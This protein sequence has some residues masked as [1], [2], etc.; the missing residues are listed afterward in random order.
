M[1][2]DE[3]GLQARMGDLAL[4]GG[5]PGAVGE[6]L[7]EAGVARPDPGAMSE[8]ADGVPRPAEEITGGRQT[9]RK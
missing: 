6:L 4:V 1:E 3:G 2:L 8:P 9:C 5:L 7:L